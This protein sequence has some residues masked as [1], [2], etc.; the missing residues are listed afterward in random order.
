VRGIINAI[1]LFNP[2]L[3]AFRGDA[4]DEALRHVHACTTARRCSPR[5]PIC[6]RAWPAPVRP[7]SNVPWFRAMLAAMT[8][9]VQCIFV[10]ALVSF[11]PPD[12]E[13]AR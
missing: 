9:S 13:I 12:V 10:L 5:S 1:N 7:A 11:V 2:P 3:H 6:A 4:L 8:Y